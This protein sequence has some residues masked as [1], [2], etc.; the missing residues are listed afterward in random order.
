MAGTKLTAENAVIKTATVEVK[1]LTISG[2]QVTLAVFR[3]LPDVDL[4]SLSDLRLNGVPWG[5]VN[6]H[7]DKCADNPEHLHVVWQEGARLLRST[8]YRE[9]DYP[10]QSQISAAAVRFALL[11]LREAFTCPEC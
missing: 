6:Y 9:M 2:R 8:T 5:H 10:G 4:I 11:K 3:Q 7:P 1:A